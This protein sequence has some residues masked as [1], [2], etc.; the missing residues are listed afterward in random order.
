MLNSDCSWK[1]NQ[2][3]YNNLI[4]ECKA[5]LNGANLF[6]SDVSA[7][8]NT[9]KNN[10]MFGS[11]SMAL[12]HHCEVHNGSKNNIFHRGATD[13]QSLENVWRGCEKNKSKI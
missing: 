11:G 8:R 4:H 3:V 9:F 12:V 10:I 6:Y 7:S 1:W 2:Y 5:Y 13:M